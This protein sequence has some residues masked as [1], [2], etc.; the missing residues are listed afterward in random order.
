MI[1]PNTYLRAVHMGDPVEVSLSELQK[2]DED[3]SLFHIAVTMLRD[4]AVA[5]V[6]LLELKH[7]SPDT[8]ENDR[9][10]FHMMDFGGIPSGVMTIPA[11]DRWKAEEVAAMLKMRLA[12]G[13]PTMISGEGVLRFPMHSARV[14]NLEATKEVKGGVQLVGET[15][16]AEDALVEGYR[17][18]HERWL[19]KQE[20]RWFDGN[21]W[22]RLRDDGPMPDPRRI[23]LIVQDNPVVDG[24]VHETFWVLLKHEAS[25]KAKQPDYMPPGAFKPTQANS[26]GKNPLY[27]GRN[28]FGNK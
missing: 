19:L 6:T 11:E 4:G 27:Q 28:F 10:I 18:E 17:N 8:P 1:G 13:V 20:K 3:P 5:F 26:K 24:A 12:D 25:E 9:L 2:L 15:K 23:Q 14:W 22:H 7:Y 16:E 21:W